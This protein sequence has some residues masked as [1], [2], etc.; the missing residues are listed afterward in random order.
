MK[1]FEIYVHI[2]FCQ[3]KC[4][5]CD[6]LSFAG[7]EE[8]QEQYVRA[9]KAEI[10][11]VAPERGISYSDHTSVVT[12]VFFG[13]GTPSVI[14]AEYLVQI[15]ETLREKFLFAPDAEI[16]LEANPGTVDMEKLSLYRKAGFNRL[17]F[18]CQ[19]TFDEQLKQLGRIH[20]YKQFLK[21]YKAARRVGFTNINVDLMSGLPGQTTEEWI[22]SLKRIADL[23]A[24]HI[25][26]YSLI[27]EEGTPFFERQDSL[28][29]PGEE[30]ERQMY[31]ST[32]E[33][34]NTYGYEQYEIS[35]YAK[36]GCRCRHNVGYWVRENYLG[37]G[38]G[39]ASLMEERRFS[40]TA[41]MKKY[42][43]CSSRPDQ[44]RE[45]LQILTTADCREEYMILGLRMRKG[46]SEDEFYRTF[47][48]TLDEVYGSVLEKYVKLE[49]LVRKDGRL[50][51]SR[52][53]IS[54]SNVIL[55]DFLD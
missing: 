27:L 2:P 40:N 29:L 5:Y 31:E 38:L 54:V 19:S 51:L 41:D 47:G 1:E 9:L 24:E 7:R 22:T 20:T 48:Q 36:P 33:V 15:L 8:M 45:N 34:L 25:S 16:S 11:A 46:I 44:I 21:E 17:S 30:E 55:A 23:G 28:K 53:G 42:L 52:R 6:F 10:E 49:M 14:K 35:N 13:G 43:E 26:A 32:C 50:F 39:A 3:Q 12:S 18:G 37:L 4:G